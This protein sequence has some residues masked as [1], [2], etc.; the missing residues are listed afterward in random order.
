[1]AFE[2]EV[3]QLE[4]PPEGAA[5]QRFSKALIKIGRCRDNDL[6]IEGTKLSRYHAEIFVADGRLRVRDL[7][8]RNGTWV[9]GARVSGEAPVEP[10]DVLMLG[11]GGP[12]IRASLVSDAP[13]PVREAPARANPGPETTLVEKLAAAPPEAPSA[14]AGA[15]A[16]SPA[17][18]NA[19]GQS[20][21][22]LA[23]DALTAEQRVRHQKVVALAVA[24]VTFVIVVVALVA[25][26]FVNRS[27]A[28]GAHVDGE[29]RRLEEKIKTADD[30]ALDLEA[31]IKER[32]EALE[33][34][35]QQQGLS[36][37]ERADMIARTEGQL[38]S[39][40]SELKKNQDAIGA[41]PQVWADL[42]ERYKE[43]VFLCVRRSRDGTVFGTAF[44]VSADGVLA[45]NAHVAVSM[46]PD[47]ETFVIQN[48]TGR[49]F[50]LR[51]RASNPDFNG[52][53]SP[54]VALLRIDTEGTKLVPLP[55]A[56]DAE[57]GKLRIG[58]QLGTLGFP[59]ELA[60]T[61]FQSFDM[62]AK[63]FKSAVATFKDGW[64]WQITN[65][66]G[67]VADFRGST[68][69][70]HSA[71]LTGGTSG[72]PMFSADGK[73]VALN[74]SSLDIVVPRGGQKITTKSAAQIG[75]AIR[76]DELRRFMA[77]KGW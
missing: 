32:D 28:E 62:K 66:Q 1:M 33:K 14:P 37:T 26:H 54:D 73:V 70:Q 39:L 60:T 67:E 19:I 41:G 57:L 48:G 56:T 6:A 52:P 38:S 12:T 71:S 16:A 34:I 36:E 23:M 3:K 77:Q 27:T 46:K 63:R 35:R 30:R 43:S 21:L 29:L 24:T 45:T 68:R 61:Y 69:I 11:E 18:K 44:A 9:N 7:G 75:Y 10:A 42:V 15:A 65:Y 2:I 58:T 47:A 74:N 51:D 72:S 4:T 8:S 20:T 25:I 31:Q 76:V 55:L 59:G 13:A 53:S 22:F 50:P 49:V 5:E 40:R 17:P 64:I